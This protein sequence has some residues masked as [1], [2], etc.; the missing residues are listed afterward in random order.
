M[1]VNLR[2]FLLL[3]GTI[4][5]QLDGNFRA[6]RREKIGGSLVKLSMGGDW[7]MVRECPLPADEEVRAPVSSHAFSDFLSVTERFR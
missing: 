6:V 3:W 1:T 7:G 4:T 5:E 2:T